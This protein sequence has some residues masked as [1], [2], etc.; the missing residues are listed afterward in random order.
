MVDKAQRQHHREE[1]AAQRDEQVEQAIIKNQ[2]QTGRLSSA[3]T[4]LQQSLEH[5]FD[6]VY[7]RTFGSKS[8]GGGARLASRAA[9]GDIDGSAAEH[10]ETQGGDSASSILTSAAFASGMSMVQDGAPAE[11]GQA[12][13]SAE[14]AFGE[15]GAEGKTGLTA[16]SA[17]AIAEMTL[18]PEGERVSVYQ[19][20]A[21]T[22]GLPLERLGAVH[23]LR[24]VESMKI[25]RGLAKMYP[26]IQR[27]DGPPVSLRDDTQPAVDQLRTAALCH[28]TIHAVIKAG[29][30]NNWKQTVESFGTV[31]RGLISL[32][33]VIEIDPSK[34]FGQGALAA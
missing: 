8:E 28:A 9:G 19:Y 18:A 34:V 24:H 7:N 10:G 14:R 25:I 16:T 3:R 31:G 32:R 11:I 5:E 6:P 33:E 21:A 22:T 27:L 12:L 17:S 26:E 4:P 29:P 1:V 30:E 15:D 20:V 23:T 2:M 13:G